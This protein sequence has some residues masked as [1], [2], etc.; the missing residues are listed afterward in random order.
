MSE[1]SARAW[2]VEGF[3]EVR[4]LGAGGQ[5]RVVLARHA[6]AGTPVA[7]K[8]LPPDADPRDIERL[9]G[10]ALMLGR[11]DDPHV[12]RLYRF[13]TGEEGAAALVMEAVNGVSLKEVLAE[14][15]AME[16]EAALT[17]LKGSLLGLAAA[18]GI[19]VV[20]R[21]YK[22]ANVVVQP[23]GVSKL[24]DFGIAASAGEGAAGGTP[25]YMAPEQ[26]DRRPASTATDVYAAT[27]VFF[28]CVTGRRPYGSAAGHRTEPIPAEAVP[29]GLR[30]LITRGMA[31]SPA[32]RPPGAAAFVRELETAASAAYGPSWEARG[33]RGLALAAAAL[34]ALFPLGAAALGTGAATGLAAGGAAGGAAAGGAAGGVA[35][36]G[37]AAGGAAGGGAAGGAAVGGAAGGGAAGGAAGGGVAG[38]GAAGGAV[39]GG[40]AGGAA[41]S[42]A[43]AGGAASGAAGSGAAG[44][45]TGVAGLLAGTGGK[46]AAA[47]VATAVAA[48]GAGVYA[49]DSGGSDPKGRATAAP[50][51]SYRLASAS[52]T[53]N[54]PTTNVSLRYPVVSGLATA[55]LEAK[56]NKVLRAPADQWATDVHTDTASFMGSKNPAKPYTAALTY[57]TGLSGPRLMS[58]RYRP[59][60]GQR[61]TVYP[62][63]VTVDLTTGRELKAPDLLRPEAVTVSGVRALGDRLMRAGLVSGDPTCRGEEHPAPDWSQVAK[64][65]KDREGR[66]GGYIKIF[67][68]P[69]RG[70]IGLPM[71]TL[72]YSMA[73][74]RASP[75]AKLPYA[76]LGD[77]L[78]PE[79]LRQATAKP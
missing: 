79:I 72:G 18:H 14:H 36:G 77:V 67:L 28:E 41:G 5:G 39:G 50:Q 22:P 6:T 4:E 73:C 21:D 63:Q 44:G 68:A 15:G 2:R 43:A 9:R 70:E 34:A 30:D 48:G 49:A 24:I 11:V 20:H 57:E 45:G 69:G 53:F 13:V 64:D 40:A 10:E 55:A 16:P 35:G 29:E 12:V 1:P 25:A 31:K 60:E 65:L 17:V 8:Y 61:N 26:W 74:N 59:Q 58:V 38:G 7:I 47:A 3:T 42:G 56:V 78:R 32:E 27:C 23:D 19:G 76:Q 33:L 66:D 51:F 37:A 75:Y 71:F 54:A 62:F 46:I 52:K